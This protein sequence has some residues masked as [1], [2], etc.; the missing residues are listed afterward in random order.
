MLACDGL[1]GLPDAVGAVWDKT[2]VQAC[3]VHV[4][5]NSLK[6]ASKR[7]G[8]DRQGPQPR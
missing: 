4:L 7:T 2:I 6:Y 1:T 8:R 3:I 5:S